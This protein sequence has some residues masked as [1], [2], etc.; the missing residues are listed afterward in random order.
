MGAATGNLRRDLR[1][2]A[3]D[4]HAAYT[5]PV[6]R[7]AFPFLLA[8]YQKGQLGRSRDEWL[9]VSWRPILAEILQR[10]G[11]EAV[12]PRVG[13]DA[14]FDLLLG[15]ILVGEYVPTSAPA[16]STD[17]T[18]DLLCRLLEPRGDERPGDTSVKGVE[19]SR[20]RRGVGRP[21]RRGILDG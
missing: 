2:F 16:Q 15:C 5:S 13:V 1:R 10:A 3:R 17:R 8:E 6:T 12:D 20:R 4:L 11:P 21:T 14:V 18:V 19:R 9:S 7:A